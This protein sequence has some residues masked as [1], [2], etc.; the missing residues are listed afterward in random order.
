MKELIEHK[1]QFTS[2]CGERFKSEVYAFEKLPREITIYK[3][4][5]PD[6]ERCREV[7]GEMMCP[8]K[9]LLLRRGKHSFIT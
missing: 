2:R 6:C 8:V 9:G 7:D 3:E 5:D 4:G 1:Y